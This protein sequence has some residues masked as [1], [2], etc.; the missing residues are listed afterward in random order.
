MIFKGRI[1]NGVVVLEQGLSLPEGAE[2]AVCYEGAA[3]NPSVVKRRIQVPLVHTGK[4][5]T[6]HL[7]GKRIAEI[8]DK[9]DVSSRR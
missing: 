9:D 4:P 6:I 1:Q 8:L 3:P 7:T 2:V 5:G